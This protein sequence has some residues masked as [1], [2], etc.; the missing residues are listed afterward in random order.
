[1]VVLRSDSYFGVD[2]TKDL[3]LDV[4]AAKEIDKNHPQWNFDDD[5]EQTNTKAEDEEFTTESDTDQD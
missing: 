2:V 1:L 4:E 5:E 3:P